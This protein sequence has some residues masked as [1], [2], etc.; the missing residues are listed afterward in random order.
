[1]TPRAVQK[2]PRPAKP[3]TQGAVHEDIR[4]IDADVCFRTHDRVIGYDPDDGSGTTLTTSQQASNG[5]RQVLHATRR[6]AQPVRRQ[7][8]RRLPLPEDELGALEHR[9]QAQEDEWRKILQP[10]RSS[11]CAGSVIST[12]SW[13]VTATAAGARPNDGE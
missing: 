5:L 2:P 13:A 3:A 6:Q 4:F 8:A 7:F 1:M 9:Q 11:N 10:R 12:G